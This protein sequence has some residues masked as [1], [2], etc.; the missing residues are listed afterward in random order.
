MRVSYL[1]QVEGGI[2]LDA[3]ARATPWEVGFLALGI[4]PISNVA[5]QG[6]FRT[7]RSAKSFIFNV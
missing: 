6:K 4:F 2:S 1:D 7:W 3:K 5:N